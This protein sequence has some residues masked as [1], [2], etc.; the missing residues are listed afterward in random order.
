MIRR[1]ALTL[2]PLLFVLDG[3]RAP[4]TSPADGSLDA[5]ATDAA[6]A[7]LDQGPRPDIGAAPARCAFTGPLPAWASAPEPSR[8]M[9]RCGE[10]TLHARAWAPGVLRLQYRSDSNA[11]LPRPWAVVGVASS[12]RETY[13]GARGDRAGMCTPDLDVTLD[14]ACRIVV[15][16]AAGSVLLEDG[17]GGG[18]SRGRVTVEGRE[19]AAAVRRWRLR[20]EDRLHGFGERNGPF[21]RRNTRAVFWNT[22]AYDPALGGVGPAA[23]PLYASIPF[24]VSHRAGVAWGTFFAD[25]HR[26]EVEVNDALTARVVDGEVDQF[27]F[28]GPRFG[29][30]LQRYAELTGAPAMPPRW[31][32]GYHQSRW[33]YNDAAR[34]EEVAARFRA[35][36]IPAD[37][38]WLD[39]QHMRGFR[40]FTWDTDRFSDPRAMNERL[41][42][43]GFRVVNIADP[44][45][46]VDPAWSVSAEGTRAGHFLRRPDGTVYSGA[47]WPGASN[48]PDFTHPAARAWWGDLVGGLA[49][50]GVSGVWLDVNE[51]TVFPESGGGSV[52][53]E[54]PVHGDGAPSTMAEAHNVYALLQARA[55]FE[56]L[57]RARPDRR[58]FVLTRAGFAGVQRF[59]AMWTG[60]TPS[61]WV[62][63]RQTLPTLLGLGMSGMPFVGSDVGGYSGRPTPELFARWVALG[64]VSPFF[65]GHVTNGVPDQEPWAF[66]TEVED[67]SRAM[68]QERYRRLPYLESLFDIAARTGAPVLRPMIWEFPDEP[69]LATVDDQAMLGPWLLVAPALSQGATERAVV[70]PRGRWMELE[71]GATYEGPTTITVNL[72][73]AALPT[74]LR[75]GATLVRAPVRQHTAE[76]VA[77]SL[78]VD[79]FPGPQ[80]TVTLLYDD[81]GDGGPAAPLARTPLG[82]TATSQGMLF[83]VGARE[84]TY[85]P[86]SRTLL[87]RVRPVDTDPSAVRDGD[88]ELTR[89]ADAAEAGERLDV[90]WWDA[91]DRALRARLTERPGARITATYTP[92]A[93]PPAE[94][95]RISLTVRV[96]DDTPRD[97]SITVATSANGWTHA[98]LTREP[99]ALVATGTITVPRGR[100]F[101]YKFA[102]GGW[103]TAERYADCSEARNRYGFGAAFP[104]RHDTVW[105]WSDRCP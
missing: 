54:L 2:A 1:A 72:T 6:L 37:A 93:A 14:S 52:P 48:F 80:R 101:E 9:A 31:A 57:R 55:T 53:D 39:I 78:D 74:F 64:A 47:V 105:R 12:P 70:L 100:W 85:A 76:T 28:A 91:N 23:D 90:W 40:T 86:P 7:P 65:R 44:G 8:L 87:L 81:N 63:L 11:P 36:R 29:D 10:L 45:L 34:L 19:R 68:I 16:D 18:F 99:G 38:V 33:G 3:C 41:A 84:G 82:L 67:I 59:A 77:P 58:P 69:G 61:T 25:P 22:D 56:G 97:A 95:V 5:R 20:D 73:L 94:S 32:L 103:S 42:A 89:V 102:R 21:E 92:A 66:G 26:M 51:P 62:G 35:L 50:E 83:E 17:E 75:Q 104:A 27:V 43:Q 13:F 60:D 30:V 24:W 49:R 71:S 4:G 15:Q 98:P 79:L 96:P 46:K 88:R